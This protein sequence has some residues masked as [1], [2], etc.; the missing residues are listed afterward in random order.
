LSLDADFMCA[1]NAGLRHARAFASR[2]R[3]DGNAAQRN[4]LYA[5]E[6][7]PTNSGTKADHRLPLRPSEIK[8]FARAVAAQ[9]GVAGVDQ[10]SAPEPAQ[11][12]IA[13]LVK[14]LQA[15]KG[16]SLVLAG[17]HQSPAVHA[18][19][20]AMNAALGNVGTTVTYTETVEMRAMDQRAGLAELVGEM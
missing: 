5:V 9:L 8:A 4:R 17:D 2:R 6:S 13:P 14:D 3:V 18:L 12:W 19:A 16:R 1:G 11:K 10:A 7:T 15:A 20:H